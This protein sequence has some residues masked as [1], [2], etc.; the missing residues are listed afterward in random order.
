MKLLRFADEK[1]PEGCYGRI[2]DDRVTIMSGSRFDDLAPTD[3]SVALDAIDHF[4]PP[5]VPP[6]IIAIGANYADH[7]RE[8]GLKPPEKPVV[9][10]KATSSLNAHENPIRLPKLYPDEVDYEAELAVVIG[11]MAS[12]VA[13]EDALSHVFGYTCANDVSARDVQRHI[14]SQWARAKSFDTFC[15]L[16]PFLV[17]DIERPE[18]LRLKTRLNGEEVQNQLASDMLFD[19]P[20]IIAHVSAG[21]TL[22]PG[23]VILTGTPAGVGMGAKPPR[24]LKPG[25][26]VEIDIERL[27]TLRNTVEATP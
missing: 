27:G 24:F 23:T 16:G 11:D 18:E 8:S 6:N 12:H 13:E 1:R 21:I 19:I 5:V 15:P 2:D 22:L 3:E 25:D 4:L 17:T 14:D 7:C 9:F 10:I 20:K 26:V